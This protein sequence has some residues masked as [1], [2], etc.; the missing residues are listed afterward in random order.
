VH[1]GA[2]TQNPVAIRFWKKHGF[3]SLEDLIDLPPSRTLW[4][5]RGVDTK[6]T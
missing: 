6:G 3:K 2:N 1:L 4:L 5:G